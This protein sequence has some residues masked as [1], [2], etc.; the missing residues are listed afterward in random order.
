MHRRGLVARGLD[1][2]VDD[3]RGRRDIGI[4][5]AEIDQRLARLGRHGGD[6]REERREVLL[7]E[8]FDSVRPRPHDP[9]LLA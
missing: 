7:G 3:V 1:E 6:A 9:M 8:P 5:A 4:A 2:C